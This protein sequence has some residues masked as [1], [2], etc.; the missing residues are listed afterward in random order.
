MRRSY[1]LLV[2]G[3]GDTVKKLCVSVM[4]QRGEAVCATTSGV[5][6]E[7]EKYLTLGEEIGRSSLTKRSSFTISRNR[8]FSPKKLEVLFLER[9]VL[10][11]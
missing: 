3:R 2:R 8:N 4:I 5:L 1:L 7:G 10:M 9:L 11:L 6:I